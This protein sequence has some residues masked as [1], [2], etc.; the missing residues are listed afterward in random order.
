MN[1]TRPSAL[2]VG[3]CSLVFLGIGTFA[4]SLPFG[5]QWDMTK[6]QVIARLGPPTS[7]PEAIMNLS[8]SFTLNY[9][10]LLYAGAHMKATFEGHPNLFYLDLSGSVPPG[11]TSAANARSFFDALVRQIEGDTGTQLTKSWVA[12]PSGPR[13]SASGATDEMSL[14]VSLYP[15][16]QA[17]VLVCSI[18]LSRF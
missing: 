4:W 16:S 18:N 10:D 9:A 2:L 13:G 11:S 17:G 7:A 14:S 6:Q 15:S 5:L 12:S 8:A 3:I 1:R